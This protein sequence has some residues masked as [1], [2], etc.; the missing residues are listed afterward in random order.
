MSLDG[1]D[2]GLFKSSTT[3]RVI[4]TYFI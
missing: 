2:D 3:K 4:R 1:I